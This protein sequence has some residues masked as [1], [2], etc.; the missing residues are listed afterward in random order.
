[1][2]RQIIQNNLEDQELPLKKRLWY[3]FKIS[4]IK[5]VLILCKMK[6]KHLHDIMHQKHF[7]SGNFLG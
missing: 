5:Q 2:V 3:V 7:G 6:Y 1:M 4:N